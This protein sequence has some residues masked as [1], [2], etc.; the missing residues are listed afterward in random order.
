MD[1]RLPL[2][3]DDNLV[4]R[5]RGPVSPWLLLALIGFVLGVAAIAA[6]LVTDTRDVTARH[7]TVIPARIL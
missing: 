2:T 6:S 3:P 7:G 4:A 1:Y 5:R